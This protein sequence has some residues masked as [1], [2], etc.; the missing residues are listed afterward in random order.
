MHYENKWTRKEIGTSK[1]FCSLI[2]H[3][4]TNG[5]NIIK[6]VGL[7]NDS[8]V[9]VMSDLGVMIEFT[10]NKNLSITYSK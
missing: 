1:K 10:V 6:I 3:E 8:K 2:H 5:G 7:I 4:Q 9:T